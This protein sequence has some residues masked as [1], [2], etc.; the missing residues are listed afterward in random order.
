MNKLGMIRL[1]PIAVDRQH[2]PVLGLV[3]K[4]QSSIGRFGGLVRIP[5]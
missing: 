1:V 4:D 2:R 3:V 5:L